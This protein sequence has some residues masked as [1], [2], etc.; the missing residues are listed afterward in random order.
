MIYLIL[1]SILWS[2]SFGIIKY[3]LSGLD[4]SYISFIR[5]VIALLFFSSI[6]IYNIKKFAFDFKLILIG[7]LQFGLMYIF[8]IQSYVY[9]PAYLIATFT[10]TTPIFVGLSSKYIANQ[11]IS[12]NG[13]Y[14]ISLVII[15][16]FLMR[17]NFV[18]PLDY[19]VGFLLIQ[20]A[21]LFF[22]SGQILFKEWKIKNKLSHKPFTI[23]IITR[24]FWT[25]YLKNFSLRIR[26]N[27]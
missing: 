13:I 15:G 16:S 20:C 2:F 21:N 18:N 5:S 25:F 17:I 11:S 14:A 1:V 12:K 22:A 10:I 9:L 3:S 23:S 24:S 26:I 8:Y 19:W 6:S 4:S 7:A 27:Y